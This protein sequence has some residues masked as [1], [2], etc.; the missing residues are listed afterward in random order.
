[1]IYGDF[2]FSDLNRYGRGLPETL[3]GPVA[4]RAGDFLN[5]TLGNAIVLGG[6][7]FKPADERVDPHFGRELVQFARGNVPGGNVFY[8]RLAWERLVLDQM[9]KLLDPEA[10]K[11][12]RR[13][14]QEWQRDFRQG[15]W[16]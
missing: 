9:Q 4:Q 14:Q 13:R 15:F 12:F 11:A 1:G 5:L 2:L 7:L 6:N 16:W 8:V 10:E 3:A